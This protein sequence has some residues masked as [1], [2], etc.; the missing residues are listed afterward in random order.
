MKYEELRM[1]E[2]SVMASYLLGAMGLKCAIRHA[3]KMWDAG[4]RPSSGFQFDEKMD[5][6]VKKRG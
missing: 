3:E 2:T 1:K 4:I 6:V 5:M